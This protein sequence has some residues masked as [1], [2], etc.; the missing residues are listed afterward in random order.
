MMTLHHGSGTGMTQ[1]KSKTETLSF[2]A[3]IDDSIVEWFI[4]DKNEIIKR[5]TSKGFRKAAVMDRARE[6]GLSEQFLKWCAL[7][8]PD[9]ALRACLGCGERFLSVGVQNRL[10]P[11]CKNKSP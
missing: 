2:T 6:L 4:K 7:G 5:L 8:N 1:A 11:R 3:S 10:C 9:V